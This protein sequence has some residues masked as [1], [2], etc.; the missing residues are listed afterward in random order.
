MVTASVPFLAAQLAELVGKR[1][2][3]GRGGGWRCVAHADEG[4][5]RSVV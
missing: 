1:R 3:G 2:E 4:T 5:G